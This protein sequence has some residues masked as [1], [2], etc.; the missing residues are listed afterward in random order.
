MRDFR[1]RDS[2]IHHPPGCVKLVDAVRRLCYLRTRLQSK[3]VLQMG[4]V[5]QA[6][7]TARGHKS[8]H[9]YFRQDHRLTVVSP[10]CRIEQFVFEVA[11]AL[12]VG[13]LLFPCSCTAVPVGCNVGGWEYHLHSA[14]GSVAD[15]RH[16]KSVVCVSL[17]G[18]TPVFN[19]PHH[20]LRLRTS[21]LFISLLSPS[22]YRYR[23][24]RFIPVSNLHDGF[25]PING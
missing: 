15:A 21:T 14:H 22:S 11:P 10:L 3:V 8:S 9:L 12:K 18:A 7:Q 1:G 2:R 5:C 19:D 16:A 20:T 24:Q 6:A 4:N 17:S 13:H 23:L 25:L